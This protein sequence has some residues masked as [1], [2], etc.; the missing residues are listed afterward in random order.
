MWNNGISTPITSLA[1]QKHFLLY[2]LMTIERLEIDQSIGYLPLEIIKELL[3]FCCI[4][5]N[6]QSIFL[7]LRDAFVLM[8]I[9]AYLRVAMSVRLSD[10]IN[11]V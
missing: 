2:G 5:I 10:M 6:T 1:T 7:K 4:Y 3:P 11:N 8:Y 9:S